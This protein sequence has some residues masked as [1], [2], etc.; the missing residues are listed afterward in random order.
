[1][2]VNLNYLPDLAT[3]PLPF[4]ESTSLNT[5]AFVVQNGNPASWRYAMAIAADLGAITDGAIMNPKLF[6]ADNIP[7]NDR[8]KFQ[9]LMVG[10]PSKLPIIIEI[11]DQLPAGFAKDNDMANEKDLQVL[12]KITPSTPVGYLE[13]LASP[14]NKNNV[15]LAVL[16]NL[17]QGIA[18][19]KNALISE[20]MRSRLS[21]NFAV[22]NDTQTLSADTRLS[23]AVE[24]TL[25]PSPAPANATSVSGTGNNIGIKSGWVFTAMVGTGILILVVLIIVIYSSWLRGRKVA[26][27]ENPE[28]TRRKE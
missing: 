12:Y 13:L 15:V 1:M 16:G 20:D 21:G 2:P 6:F 19:A 17:P 23:A 24:F 7:V 5:T 28:E 8:S 27:K 26:S 18:W 22:I 10:A 9:F 25:I 14:W 4:I 3:Y 11:N